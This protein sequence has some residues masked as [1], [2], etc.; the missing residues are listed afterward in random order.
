MSVFPHIR[1]S[2]T[3][4]ER[5]RQLGEQAAERIRR[6]I[7]IYREIFQHYSGWEWPQVLD[8]T[9]HYRPAIEA[10]QPRYLE[11]IEGIA[12]GAQIPAEEVL[13]INVRTEIMFAAVARKA[14]RECSALALMPPATSDSHPWIA[15]NW[16][17][18]PHM[19]ETVIVLEATQDEGPDYITV[20][21]AGLLAKTGLNSAG[22]GLVTNALVS[23]EDRGEPG[24][25][26]HV[27][28]RGILDAETM[29][30]ALGAITRDVRS[31]SANYLIAHREGE[32]INIEAA[33]GDYSRISL[34]FPS[35]RGFLVHTNHFCSVPSDLKDVGLWE[36]T[37]S[38]FRL[39]RLEQA[40]NRHESPLS[41]EDIQQIF[42]DHFDFPYS[43]C[44]HPDPRVPRVEQYAT[45]ASI[46]IDLADS[47]MWIAD[48]N[49][50]ETS[51][52]RIEYSSFLSK[53]PSFLPSS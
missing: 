14:A 5:G 52:R 40:I 1:V 28:L 27:I 16:D 11:E 36:G 51:F 53:P 23:S 37:D 34:D 13:A 33:P 30:D 31:S 43:V 26:Y 8:H 18:K 21:E 24:V 35:E 44:S 10:Y 7:A 46:M 47:V 42:T 29:T 9:Q 22:I 17:W 50:C 20:V 39:R 45:V 15:Q 48:G 38:P 2:G 19:S 6:S 4:A 12:S 49:P 41:R 25:P 3:P 32:A